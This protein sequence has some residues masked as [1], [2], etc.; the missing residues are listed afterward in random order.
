[1][2]WVGEDGMRFYAYGASPTHDNTR[3]RRQ[4]ELHAS[5]KRRDGIARR[6]F[7]FRFPESVVAARSVSELR[8]MEGIRVR[9]LYA[10]MGREFGVTWKG[11]DYNPNNWS[12]A[13]N[14]NRAI[15]AAN[16]SLYAVC[17]AVVCSMGYLPQLGFVHSGGTL[18]F[19]YDIADLYK[20]ETTLPAAFLA[21]SQ[22]ADATTDY[23]LALLKERIE[24][25][26][27]LRRMPREIEELLS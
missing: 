9:D 15:S 18:P 8:G 3:A 24:A 21:T 22:N 13:D 1:M 7:S 11:R 14:I 19:V 17:T 23:V 20:P 4:A 16:A 26:R 27:L 2:C 10:E 5:K 12:L 6:M 25:C